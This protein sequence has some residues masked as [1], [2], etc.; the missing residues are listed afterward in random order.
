[1]RPADAEWRYHTD[2]SDHRAGGRRPHQA[3][4]PLARVAKGDRVTRPSP[5]SL[6]WRWRCGLVAAHSPTAG[7]PVEGGAEEAADGRPN[8]VSSRARRSAY[9]ASP[10]M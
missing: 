7:A 3:A 10:A 8:V 6:G 2:A 4:L 1:Y 5:W 9:R